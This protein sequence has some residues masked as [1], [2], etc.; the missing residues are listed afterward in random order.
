[1]R[2]DGEIKRDVEKEILWA[3]GLDAT[4]IIVGVKDGIVTLSG[5][6][7][8]YTDKYEAEAAAKRVVGVV[9]L[10]NAIE[11]YLPGSGQRPDP[12]IAREAVAAIRARLPL[13]WEHIKLIVKKGWI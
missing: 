8:R 9:G 13:A 12:E 5:F 6:V 2:L 7:R 1:M 10:A 3:P 4:D 11:V